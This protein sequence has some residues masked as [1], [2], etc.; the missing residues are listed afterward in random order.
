MT[1]AVITAHAELS[2]AL[3]EAQVLD[4]LEELGLEVAF[5]D[6]AHLLAFADDSAVAAGQG[7]IAEVDFYPLEG[8][9]AT[10]VRCSLRRE[11]QPALLG[12]LQELQGLMA[13]SPHWTVDGCLAE[14]PEPGV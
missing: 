8:A 12:L 6:S 9:G 1:H 3:A 7:A 10:Q 13:Q 2:L 11:G 14:R 5:G 4:W